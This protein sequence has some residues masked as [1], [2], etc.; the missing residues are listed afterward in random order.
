V[1]QGRVTLDGEVCRK[2]AEIVGERVVRLD[3]ELVTPAPDVLHLVLHKPLGFACSHDSAETPIVD[4]LLPPEWLRLGLQPAGRLDRETSGLLVLST[5]GQIVHRLTHPAR[6]VGKR[7][8]I[9][10]T[11]EL[12]ADAAEQCAAGL[13]LEQGDEPT[14]PAE[15]ELEGAGRATLVLREGRYHQVRR[16]IARLGAEVVAL[17]RD[18]VGGY[19]LPADLE[20]GRWRLLEDTDLE[21]LLSDSSL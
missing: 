1:R 18:R 7:Y 2:A 16:M 14:R 5:D 19:E 6:K 20:A 10:Y 17:H 9:R 13:S 3:A 4:E 21:R 12:V 11:G 8:R 15:L